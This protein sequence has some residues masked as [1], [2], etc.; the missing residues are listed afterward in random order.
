MPEQITCPS[1]GATLRVPETLL[2]KNVKCPKC[3][4]TFRAQTQAAAEPEEP[5]E[6]VAREPAPARASSRRREPPPED[7]DDEGPPPEEDEDEDRPRR[8]RRGARAAMSAVAGPAISLMVVAGLSIVCG[9][10][11][12]VFRIINLTVGSAAASKGA[13]ASYQA[14]TVA[15]TIAGAGWDVLGL[16]VSAII[17]FGA[18]KMKNLQS[19]GFAM[20]TCI[21][22][23]LPLHCCCLLGLPFGIW[24]LVAI[25]NADVKNAFS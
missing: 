16:I 19:F 11:D 7:Y 14:G 22:A 25:N 13:A 10:V 9:L 24:G 4:N 18:L 3:Q 5:E 23:M 8:G 6:R 1:C 2:G 21:L 12:L 20:T 17:I 15:G